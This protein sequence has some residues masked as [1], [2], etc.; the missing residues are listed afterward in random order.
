MAGALPAGAVKFDKQL[1]ALSEAKG[2]EEVICRFADGEE[3]AFDLVVG[4]DGVKSKVH[5]GVERRRLCWEGAI[6]E[7]SVAGKV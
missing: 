4:C 7:K 5:V 1:V 2:G 3:E 6:S